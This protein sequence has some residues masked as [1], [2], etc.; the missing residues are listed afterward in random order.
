M[1]RKTGFELFPPSFKYAVY[2][3]FGAAAVG[4]G[5]LAL[6]ANGVAQPASHIPSTEFAAVQPAADG[7]AGK[8]GEG[9]AEG[10]AQPAFAAGEYIVTT[11]SGVNIRRKPTEDSAREGGLPRGAEVSVKK[12]ELNAAGDTWGKTAGGWIAM[13][14]SGENYVSEGEMQR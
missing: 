4:L 14:H 12:T 13:Q 10:K 8:A 5:G 1:A 9:Q 6:Y 3:M 2:A 7:S 11:K